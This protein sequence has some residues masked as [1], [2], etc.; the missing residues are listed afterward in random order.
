MPHFLP[1]SC[2]KRLGPM[3]SC[4]YRTVSSIV[5]IDRSAQDTTSTRFRNHSESCWE[6]NSRDW[7]LHA[8]VAV[9]RSDTYLEYSRAELRG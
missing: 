6:R 4:W 8:I 1:H 9:H 3:K 2:R 7:Q 5:E